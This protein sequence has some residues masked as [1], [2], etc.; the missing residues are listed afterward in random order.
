MLTV[1]ITLMYWQSA[2]K[3]KGGV[4]T[5]KSEIQLTADDVLAIGL[6]GRPFLHQQGNTVTRGFVERFE[7]QNDFWG[8]HIKQ[9]EYLD[10]A[11]GVWTPDRETDTYGGTLSIHASFR[12]DASSNVVSIGGY[13]MVTHVGPDVEN[14]WLGVDWPAT[15]LTDG[16]A[17]P[18]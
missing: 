11:T 3:R 15:D 9:V 7:I 18:G 1:E 2:P 8:L 17:L 12:K 16:G 14:P 5:M 6:S 13:G 4:D 10:G